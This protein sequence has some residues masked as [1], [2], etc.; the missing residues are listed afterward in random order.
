MAS[1]ISAT[2]IYREKTHR[3]AS[4]GGVES[5]VRLHLITRSKEIG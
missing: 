1:N 5:V 4:D 2:K 3:V